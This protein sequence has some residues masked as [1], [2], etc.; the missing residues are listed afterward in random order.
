MKATAP[1]CRLAG[2]ALA[3]PVQAAVGR[4]GHSARVA[5]GAD[6]AAL[7]G[8]GDQKVVPTVVAT[9]PRKAVSKDAAFE[10]FAKRLLDIRWRGVVVTLA[11]KL[12]GAG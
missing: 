3:A 7:A 5:R 10:V 8:E 12:A 1:R 4:L 9:C 6:T 11:V 2:S